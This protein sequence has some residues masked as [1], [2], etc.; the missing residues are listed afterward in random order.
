MAIWNAVPAP[1][2]SRG[3]RELAAR[4]E[5][6]PAAAWEWIE[7]LQAARAAHPQATPRHRGVVVTP[8][9]I[10]ARMAARAV[11]AAPRGAVLRVLDAGCGDGR[12]LAAVA[13]AA[14]ERRVHVDCHGVEIDATAA[15]W[16]QGLEPLVRAGAGAALARWR[17]RC[18]DFLARPSAVDAVDVVI[19]NPPYVAWRGLDAAMRQRLR[20]HARSDLAA[21]F[22]DRLLDRLRPGGTLVAI[23]P[24][25]LLVAQY[26]AALRLRLRTDFALEELWDLATDGVFHGHGVYPVVLVARRIAL[27]AARSLRVF[28]AAGGERARWPQGAWSALPDAVLPLRLEPR[29]AAIATRLLSG[30]RLGQHATFACGIATSG[31]GRAVGAGPDRILRARDVRPFRAGPGCAFDVRRAG[32][33]ARAVARQRVVKVIVPG[34]FRRLCAAFDPDARLLGRVYW[35]P[36]G[37]A[38]AAARESERA[39]LLALLNSRLYALLYAGLFGGGSQSGGY[40]RANGPCLAALPW[41]SGGGGA[42]AA[43]VACVRRLERRPTSADLACLDAAVETLFALAPDE[44]AVLEALARNLPPPDTA[45]HD[46]RPS[47]QRPG[48]RSTRSGAANHGKSERYTSRPERQQVGMDVA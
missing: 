2:A 10:A 42:P 37:G 41:P 7:R 1:S 31:F 46:L 35:A 43:L 9:P 13:R 23:V 39:L 18:G 30:D 14:A 6:S 25:K 24:N 16:A 45:P 12:L 47:S 33:R 26:A 11:A 27:A 5:S 20:A 8:P 38:T 3:L 29:L 32:L 17:V 36:L 40:L 44:R 34:L 4:L 22:V 28:D 21:I 15:R 48:R 19:A